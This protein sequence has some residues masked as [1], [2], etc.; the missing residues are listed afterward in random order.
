MSR[1]RIIAHRGASGYLP[2]HTALAK[3][4]AYGLGADFI[5]QDLVAT[6]DHEV[7]VL[8]DIWL[9]DVSNVAAVYPDRRRP[10]GRFYVVDFTLEELGRLS[11]HERRVPDSNALRF[12][13][14]FPYELPA[15]RIQTFAEEIRLIAGLNAST[16]RHVGIYPE[17]KDPAW[18]TGAGIDLTRLVHQTLAQNRD[19]ISGPVLIQSF[20]TTALRR[21]ASELAT[22]WPL[23]QLLDARQATE[24]EPADI[25]AIASYAAGVGLPFATLIAPELVD[26]RAVPTP[27]TGRL[28]DAG[29]VV[30]PYTMRRDV[31]P[32][33]PV[34]YVAALRF[35]IHELEVDGLFCDHPDDALAVRDGSSV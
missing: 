25:E 35:L 31:A 29:L 14:R 34:D 11:L 27:L 21:A 9:D 8:H 28:R 20:D 33:G 4:M 10:D 16:G 3:A 7:V 17:I 18:H 24:L 30:H 12:P 6:Q 13:G 23:V 22:E 32:D 15:F 26:G 1:T 2:E 19:L 5:E